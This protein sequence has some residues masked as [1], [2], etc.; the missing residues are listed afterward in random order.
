MMNRVLV[1][2]CCGAGKSTFA[3]HLHQNTGLPVI[4]LDQYYWKPGWKETSEEEWNALVQSLAEVDRWI[5]DGNYVSS[6]QPRLDRADTIVYLQYSTFKCLYRVIK[7]IVRY[8][9][10]VRPDMPEG[11]DERFDLEFL[12][13]VLMFNYLRGNTLVRRLQSLSANKHVHILTNDRE[14]K[15]WLAGGRKEA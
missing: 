6:L 5:I 15:E 8:R 1:L 13:Y 12:H 11:C 4:H 7:R 9:G 10:T 14:V 3:R 2:G